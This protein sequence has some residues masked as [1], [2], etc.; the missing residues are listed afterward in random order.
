MGEGDVDLEGLLGVVGVRV[1]DGH[2][3]VEELDDGEDEATLVSHLG[4]LG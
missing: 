4:G 1:V 3:A 2:L